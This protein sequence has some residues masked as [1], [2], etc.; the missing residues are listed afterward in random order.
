M[1]SNNTL[2]NGRIAFWDNNKCLMI[3]LVV[4]GH[5]AEFQAGS[6]DICKSMFLFIYTF[7]MPMLLFVSGVF[8]KPEKIIRKVFFYICCGYLLKILLWFVYY[9]TTKKVPEFEMFS[10]ITIPWFMFVLA[11]Y[12]VVSYLLRKINLY[13]LLAAGIILACFAGYDKGIGDFLYISRAIVFLPFFTLGRIFKEKKTEIVN[14]SNKYRVVLTVAAV[15]IILIWGYT[16]FGQIDFVDSLRHLFTGRNPYKDC[17]IKYGI[18]ARLFCYAVSFL[19]CASTLILTPRKNIPAF[20]RIGTKTLDIYFWH[21]AILILLHRLCHLGRLFDFGIAGKLGYFAIAAALIYALT[22]I[23]I[24]EFPLKQVK[25]LCF[26]ISDKYE[27]KRS[28]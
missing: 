17:I 4:F 13:L 10:D 23:K 22:Y 7:H 25:K 12:Q 26:S 24:F 21:W 20:T 14:W 27:L 28:K 8:F 11:I 16:C 2:S 1:V 18:S 3:C 9:I 19:M 6:S 5:F 15:V